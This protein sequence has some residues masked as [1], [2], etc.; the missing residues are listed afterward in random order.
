MPRS[1]GGTPGMF[2]VKP[3]TWTSYRIVRSHGIRGLAAMGKEGVTTTLRG[4]WGA[5][6]SGDRRIGYSSG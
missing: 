5:E 2:F 4:M 6:S 1:S 3:L